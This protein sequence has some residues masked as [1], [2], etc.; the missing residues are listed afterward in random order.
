MTRGVRIGEDKS[1]EGEGECEISDEKAFISL[2][3]PSAMVI[4][5]S[6]HA[7]SFTSVSTRIV[8]VLSSS[9]VKAD[10]HP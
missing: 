7:L 1:S 2:S 10:A 4:F 6:S 5:A 8:V 9:K 3:C